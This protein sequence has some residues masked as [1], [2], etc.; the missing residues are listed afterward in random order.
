MR[1]VRM[2]LLCS[3][4]LF[5]ATLSP[6]V[7]AVAG[8]TR[9]HPHHSH[10]ASLLVSGLGSGS[11]S[12][13]GP[14]GALYVAEPTA[15]SIVR[16]DLRTGTTSAFASGLPTRLDGLTV[17]GVMDVAFLGHTAYAIVSVVGPDVGGTSVVGLY[18]IDGP[19]TSTVVADIGAWS[20]DHPP[21]PPFFVA[22]GVQ[23]AMQ[24]WHHGFL[25]T[26]GHHNRVL[27]VTT[28][29]D[30]SEVIA[31][32]NVVPTGIDVCRRTVYLAEAGPVPHDPAEGKVV[33]FTPGSPTT[34]DV[35]AG[36]S[37]LTDVELAPAGHGHHSG[38]HDGHGH[39]YRHGGDHARVSLYAVS[40][41]TYSGDPEGSP[42]LPD[43]GSL[44]K[45]N[46]AGGF[47]VVARDLDRPTS[48]ELARRN[49]Y[50]VT[51]DG[52]VWV[53][54]LAHHHWS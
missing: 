29:G 51:Y 33:A 24:P 13:I 28:G 32:G 53:V 36:A 23:Y 7:A 43:T 45:A 17:G 3:T 49:A 21:T 10:E 4:V 48:L 34:D 41:G 35:A 15:G 37:I 22:T 52:E 44:V 1:S 6:S 47:D 8:G 54:P 11:G 2:L 42:G 14:D 5:L 27:K 19:T 30:I 50:V 39:A 12:T 18:R 9:A 38:H 31:F 25:V 16:V 46:A 26:D 40:N 20:I